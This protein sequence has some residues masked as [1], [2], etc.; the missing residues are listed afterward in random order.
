MYMEMLVCACVHEHVCK[1]SRDSK[2]RQKIS[3]KICITEYV[4]S[5][6]RYVWMFLKSMC[7]IVFHY[8]RRFNIFSVSTKIVWH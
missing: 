3:N 6:N 1:S 7:N 8:S 2:V 4:A 5:R